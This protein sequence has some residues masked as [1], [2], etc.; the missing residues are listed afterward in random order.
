MEEQKRE[1]WWGKKK[2]TVEDIQE[3]LEDVKEFNCGAIDAYLDNHVEKVFK[4]WA[5]KKGIDI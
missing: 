2:F 1:F 4:E 3:L 5:A